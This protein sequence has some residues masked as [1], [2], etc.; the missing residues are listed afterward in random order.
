[1]K[2]M[3]EKVAINSTKGCEGNTMSFPYDEWP[4][5]LKEMIKLLEDKPYRIDFIFEK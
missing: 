4:K 2:S 1:M 5:I 3:N